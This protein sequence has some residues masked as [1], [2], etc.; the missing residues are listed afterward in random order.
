MVL[1]FFL[2][3]FEFFVQTFGNCIQLYKRGSLVNLTWK[4]VG[5]IINHKVGIANCVKFIIPI[6]ESL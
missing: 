2:F 1:V 4:G 5:G 3:N 6:L